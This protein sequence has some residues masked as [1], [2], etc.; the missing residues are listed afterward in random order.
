MLEGGYT[1][2]KS[3]A[4]RKRRGVLGAGTARECSIIL[5][6]HGKLHGKDDKRCKGH[7]GGNSEE[8]ISEMCVP[9][10]GNRARWEHSSN[11]HSKRKYTFWVT[12]VG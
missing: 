8:V 12:D 6:G 5:G 9:D 2:L 3:K 4:E 7:E 11:I 10:K 1:F